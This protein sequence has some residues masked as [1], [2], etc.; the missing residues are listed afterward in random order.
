MK[1]SVKQTMAIKKFATVISVALTFTLFPQ[2]NSHA[3]EAGPTFKSVS[4]GEHF[5]CGLTTL[6]D[7]YC[8]GAN[9]RSQLGVSAVNANSTPNKVYQ[10]SNAVEIAAGRDFACA[11][12][13]DG[14]VA[15]WGR[16][17]LG[18]T[19]DGIDTKVDR[20]FATRVQSVN[21]AVGIVAGFSHA[22][23]LL[24]DK[25]VRCWG[26][27]QLYQLGNETSKI[28]TMPIQV[29]GIPSVKEISSGANHTCAISESGFVYCW[30]DNKF[31]QLGI[32]TMS[33]LK[34]KP[35][36]ALGIKKVSKIQMGYN[37]SCASIEL[38]GFT[39]WGWGI[40][41]QLA[42]TDRFNRSLPV[43]ITLST[44]TDSATALV[45]ISLGRTKSCGLLN[46]AKS[47]L[48]YCWGTT[49]STDPVS[50]S[51]ATS[52]SLG[53]DHGCTVTTTGTVQC[54]GWNHKGQLGLGTTSN[55]VSSIALVSGFPDWA[56]W[57]N[58]WSMKYEDNLGILSWT[59]GTGKYIISI[60]GRG[61][62]CETLIGVK[63]CKFG[64]L[65]SNKTYTGTI[66]AQNT[67]VIL[68]RT[69]NISFTTGNLVSALDQY[70][71]DQ[72]AASAAS[73][74]AAKDKADL[75]KANAFI[76]TLSKQIEASDSLASKGIAQLALMDAKTQ[77][78]TIKLEKLS[79]QI[80]EQSEAIK[81]IRK[82][83]EETVTKILKKI[84]S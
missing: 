83:I 10:V 76:L 7:V 24:A 33:I 82:S 54:W 75:E 80:L 23:V 32:G 8:W 53:S 17:D 48:M 46:S 74:K 5:T 67:P 14:G 22:C 44:L 52:V 70:A 12:I 16:G 34:S 77:A 40:D 21:T 58:T 63:S 73:A 59:G 2:N 60:D 42:E 61:I 18:Q 79:A 72:A 41:G 65:E 45:S 81:K 50:G 62:V 31:G 64:P 47:N 49:V 56:Y 37:S 29:E 11:R 27:N 69:V 55:A 28:E 66:T 39:C 25:T 3:V 71:V 68:S 36:T 20:I 26:E 84:G 4:S 6:G 43:P 38:T 19:G 13:S 57:I 51:A 1:F 9:D 35:M 15:C 78:E 30:G